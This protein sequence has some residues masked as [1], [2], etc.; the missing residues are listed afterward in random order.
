[1][2]RLKKAVSEE[3]DGEV[4]R[5]LAGEWMWMH[6]HAARCMALG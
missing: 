4:E 3:L 1:M 6:M 5:S 2:H